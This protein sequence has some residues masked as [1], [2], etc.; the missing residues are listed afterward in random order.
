MKLIKLLFITLLFTLTTSNCNVVNKVRARNVI[1]VGTTHTVIVQ[2]VVNED[3]NQL[4]PLLCR[5]YVEDIYHKWSI[6]FYD[7][8]NK[9]NTMDTVKIKR[10]DSNRIIIL[11]D[12]LK[13]YPS[14]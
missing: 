12:Y 13:I 8:C 1:P 6:N 2:A 7:I 11:K 5:Y 14:Q 3:N 4:P 10:F 9:G